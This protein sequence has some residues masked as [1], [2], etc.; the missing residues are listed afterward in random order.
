VK[1]LF[2]STIP[3]DFLPS[4]IAHYQDNAQSDDSIAFYL[5]F[6]FTLSMCAVKWITVFCGTSRYPMLVWMILRLLS[7]IFEASNTFLEFT[8]IDSSNLKSQSGPE[9]PNKSALQACEA[10]VDF[11]LHGVT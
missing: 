6:R 7:V 9:R 3:C 4:R 10:I 11:L 5:T 1:L 8:A 2:C